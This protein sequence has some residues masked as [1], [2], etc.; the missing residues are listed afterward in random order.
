MTGEGVFLSLIFGKFTGLSHALVETYMSLGVLCFVTFA[1]ASPLR[2][3]RPAV[4]H[5]FL[6]QRHRN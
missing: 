6:V 3:C 4:C 5:L 2:I 1:R